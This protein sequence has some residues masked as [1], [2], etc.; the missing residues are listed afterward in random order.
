VYNA[1][2]PGNENNIVAFRL[3]QNTYK[4]LVNKELQIVVRG[5][6]IRF[7]HDDDLALALAGLGC[8]TTARASHVEPSGEGWKA[9]LFPVGGP[10][11]GPFTRRDQALT[12]EVEWLTANNTPKPFKA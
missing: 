9:D 3:S 11:L 2:L 8:S 5:S 7:M 6:E 4:L 1:Q 10:V 12:A